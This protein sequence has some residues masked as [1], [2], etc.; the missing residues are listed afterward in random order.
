[1]TDQFQGRPWAPT[2]PAGGP[3]PPSTGHPSGPL[4]TPPSG[5]PPRR[6]SPWVWVGVAVA[7]LVLLGGVITAGA[8][9]GMS[10]RAPTPS[11]STPVAS[12]TTSAPYTSFP[13]QPT[14]PSANGW[15]IN[16][17]F[18]SGNG[19]CRKIDPLEGEVEAIA[20]D[21]NNGIVTFF[22]QYAGS[23]DQFVSTTRS[24]YATFTFI[25]EDTCAADYKGTLTDSEGRQ[26]QDYVRI[27]KNSPFT[28][29]E[30]GVVGQVT[31][32]QL[33]DAP[34]TVGDHA[35]LCGP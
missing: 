3:P 20:C 30:S 21:T 24:K 32:Q 2:A 23:F 17:M 14:T 18:G 15:N 7:V 26:Y 9:A 27:Y 6:T 33:V 34:F 28:W 1:M 12:P 35:A 31:W 29:A 4:P 25:G 8:V 16:T 5:P 22:S 11:P 13:T 10:E 19:E